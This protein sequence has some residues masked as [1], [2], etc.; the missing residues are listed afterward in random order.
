MDNDESDPKID[1]VSYHEANSSNIDVNSVVALVRRVGGELASIDEK[2]VD[3]SFRPALQIDKTKLIADLERS[4]NPNSSQQP[5][6]PPP[7]E[8]LTKVNEQFI[9][10]SP[11][12][13]PVAPRTIQPSDSNL[14]KRITRLESATKAFKAARKIKKG[15]TY[16]VSSNSMKGQIKDAELLAE[17][18][19]SEVA[20]GVKTIT[21]KLHENSDS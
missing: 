1:W 13:L 7:P 14:E 16:T 3:G 18:V 20:K 19:M 15:M 5:S 8:N 11:P 2:K 12:V 9:T 4:K 10:Q 21:I 6:I 17:F